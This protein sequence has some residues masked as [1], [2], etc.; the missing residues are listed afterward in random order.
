MLGDVSESWRT[1]EHS[2]V[3]AVDP[4]RSDIPSRL[5]KRLEFFGDLAVASS[6]T[7]AISTIL[8][9]LYTPVVSTSMTAMRPFGP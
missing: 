3:D 7:T 5:H 2:S 8:S 1:P 6:V 9:V 4:R